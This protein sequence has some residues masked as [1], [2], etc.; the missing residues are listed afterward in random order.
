MQTQFPQS[1]ISDAA[2]PDTRA[3]GKP[4]RELSDESEA[5]M[6]LGR[7]C[8]ALILMAAALVGQEAAPSVRVTGA[9]KQALALTADDLGKMPRASVKTD[10][11]GIAIV[12]E[13]VW[14]HDVLKRAGVPMG[15]DLRGKALASYVLAEAED[16]YQVLFS[17]GELDPEF[18]DNQI[19]LADTANGRPLFGSQGRF[20]LVAPKEKRGARSVRMLTRLDVV[21]LRK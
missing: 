11:D 12:Y 2:S 8:L 6:K 19:L 20:R 3:A 9:V 1:R 21:M 13:G 7:F 14:L 5:A 10:S 15:T 17:L 16:G 4:I 18:I